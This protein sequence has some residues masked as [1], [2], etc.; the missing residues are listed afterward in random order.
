MFV[1]FGE[2]QNMCTHTQRLT[3]THIHTHTRTLTQAYLHT[4]ACSYTVEQIACAHAPGPA[5]PFL[6]GSLKES[7]AYHLITSL[8]LSPRAAST[9][10]EDRAWGK[11]VS[12]QMACFPTSGSWSLPLHLGWG[13]GKTL[14]PG[15]VGCRPVRGRPSVTSGA[16]QPARAKGASGESC[17]VG[18][19]PRPGQFGNLPLALCPGM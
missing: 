3:H 12:F 15:T 16:F 13:C 18:I 5:W 9:A 14:S 1:S 19:C 11:P 6:C 2:R 7:A 10:H 8:H 17:E 4:C